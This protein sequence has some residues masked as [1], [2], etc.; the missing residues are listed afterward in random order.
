[1]LPQH[2]HDSTA[3]FSAKKTFRESKLYQNLQKK[4]KKQFEVLAFSTSA[5]FSIHSCRKREKEISKQ[6]K[7]TN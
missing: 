3:H 1:M 5:I 7:L 6:V 2:Q 4:H